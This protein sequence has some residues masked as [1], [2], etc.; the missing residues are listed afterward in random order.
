MCQREAVDINAKLLD[1][2]TTPVA[3]TKNRQ[4]DNISQ[5]V[6]IHLGRDSV[7][8]VIVTNPVC[9]NLHLD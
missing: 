7:S 4:G 8:G 5:V 2:C 9:L 1:C 3:R 6:R